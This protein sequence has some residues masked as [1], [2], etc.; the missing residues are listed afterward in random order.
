MELNALFIQPTRWCGKNCKGCYVKAHAGGENSPHV[1]AAVITD[2]LRH[3]YFSYKD[4]WANQIT[5]SVDD[6]PEDTDK[7]THMDTILYYFLGL[8]FL[9]AGRVQDYPELHATFHN[10]Q[11]MEKYQ[12]P[13]DI[14][15][16]AGSLD[17]LSLSEIK[18]KD[19]DI[20]DDLATYTKINYNHLIPAS[21][22]LNNLDKYVANMIEIGRVVDHIYLVI[23]KTPIGRERS[24][25]MKE[26]DASQMAHDRAV[27]NQLMKR[28]PE[29]VK[30]K[31]TIDGCLQDVSKFTR[32]GFG[33]SSNVSRVQVWP[34]GSTSGCAY[35]FGTTGTLARGVEDILE[36]IKAARQKYDFKEACHLVEAHKSSSERS[37][38]IKLKVQGRRSFLP[39]ID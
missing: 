4:C 36:N 24:E 3:Y 10:I 38:T 13:Y 16:M 32:T 17:M 29:D 20:I 26:Q 31:I 28:L 37:Q 35:A 12:G 21:L 39:I 5:L 6:P 2:L 25:A 19:L 11:T 15:G 23:N 7:Y 34:D 8:P 14:F 22:R 18:L 30:K 33:C 27:I 9:K 1:A